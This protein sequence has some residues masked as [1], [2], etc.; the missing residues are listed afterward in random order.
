MAIMDPPTDSPTATTPTQPS[1]PPL[2]ESSSSQPQPQ[3]PIYRLAHHHYLYHAPTIAHLRR[4]HQL[5][6]TLIGTL[7]QS[8][9]QNLFLGLPLLLMPEEAALLVTKGVVFIADD[10]GAHQQGVAEMGDGVEGSEDGSRRRRDWMQTLGSVG[11]DVAAGLG[12]AK[13]RERERALGRIGEVE[14]RK[15]ERREAEG[16]KGKRKGEVSS[17]QKEDAAT[18]V[19]VDAG[20]ASEETLF[21]RSAPSA[22]ESPTPPPSASTASPSPALSTATSTTTTAPPSPYPQIPSYTLTPT[23]SHPPLPLPDP[24]HL[25]TYPPPSPNPLHASLT[26]RGYVLTP[27][28]RFGSQYL[29]YPGDPLRYHSHFLVVGRGWDEEVELGTLVG[30]GR[31]GTGVKK[32]V[33]FGGVERGG[34]DGKREGDGDGDEGGGGGGGGVDRE[35]SK[36][37][38]GAEE[39]EERVRCF[40]IEWGGM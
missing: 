20:D 25:P 10:V 27:G 26:A 38:G 33:C 3:I 8:S 17:G 16:A 31:L 12:K 19:D 23:T 1:T 22:T 29:A 24:S 9:Q 37:E 28:L 6:G 2:P 40:T 39:E 15:R 7:P 11:R 36:D 14:M 32:G 5:P 35:G 18:D 13:G 21:V 30:L 4:T 34:G